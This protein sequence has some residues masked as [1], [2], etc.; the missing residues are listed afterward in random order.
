MTKSCNP[1]TRRAMTLVELLAA[2]VLA[3]LLLTASFGVLRSLATQRKALVGDEADEPWRKQL[4]ELLRW[5]LIN[6]RKMCSQPEELRL[7]G[8]GGTDFETAAATLR[9]T[10]II[11]TIRT[12]DNR[13]RLFRREI[14]LDSASL[15][16]SRNE[17]VAVG[18]AAINVYD[19]EKGDEQEMTRTADNKPPAYVRISNRVRIVLRGDDQNKA[20]MDELLTLQ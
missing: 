3:V 18:I 6:A 4:S 10:E 11:Y 13:S 16:N 20:I 7:I 9:P 14:H 2:T 5:D 8:Y 12:D 19:P 17:L 1:T 15:D